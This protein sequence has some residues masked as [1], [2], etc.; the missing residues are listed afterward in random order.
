ML[1][2]VASASSMM[3]W[4]ISLHIAYEHMMVFHVLCSMYDICS[5]LAWRNRRYEGLGFT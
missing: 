4:E 3:Y 1:L 5:L 2:E